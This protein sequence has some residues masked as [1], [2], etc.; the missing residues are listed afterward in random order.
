MAVGNEPFLKTYNNTYLPYTLPALKNIQQALTH[1]HLSSTVKPT[2]PLNADVYFS[3]ESSPV[4]SSGD[5]RPDTKPA[6]LEIVNFLHSVDAPFTVNIYPFLSLYQ[7]PNF[8]LDFAFFD[9]S[10]KRLRDGENG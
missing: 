10:Y 9:S 1:S 6:T 8:P 4:P 3:P 5:F 2:V 7:N